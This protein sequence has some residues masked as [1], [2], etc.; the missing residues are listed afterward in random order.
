MEPFRVI[1]NSP[2]QT[3]KN[4]ICKIQ[5]W[6]DILPISENTYETLQRRL[7]RHTEMFHKASF[8]HYSK[9]ERRKHAYVRSKNKM[10]LKREIRAAHIKT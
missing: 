7:K 8:F 1:L 4:N 5:E 3:S 6:K 10:A 9:A 2:F